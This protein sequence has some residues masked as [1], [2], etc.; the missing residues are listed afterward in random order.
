MEHLEVQKRSSLVFHFC[1]V[2]SFAPHALLGVVGEM[3]LFAVIILFQDDFMAGR[4]VARFAWKRT[5]KLV[6]DRDVFHLFYWLK[7]CTTRDGG[8]EPSV[9]PIFNR[10]FATKIIARPAFKLPKD[11]VTFL[12]IPLPQQPPL[13]FLQLRLQPLRQSREFQFFLLLAYIFKI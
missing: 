8:I 7:N 6:T 12:T 9:S 4:F 5:I 3:G 11:R 2:V 1:S 10:V 13:R